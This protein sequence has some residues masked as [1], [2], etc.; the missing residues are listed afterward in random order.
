MKPVEVAFISLGILLLVQGSLLLVGAGCITKRRDDH[1]WASIGVIL[2]VAQAIINQT[3]AAAPWA[4]NRA[5][6]DAPTIKS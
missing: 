6:S 2:S 5:F 4:T 1:C 3:F